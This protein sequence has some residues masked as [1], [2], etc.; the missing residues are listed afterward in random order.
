ML[1]S[2]SFSATTATAGYR[3]WCCPWPWLSLRIEMQPLLLALEFVL[4]H[5][6]GLE[7]WVLGHVIVGDTGFFVSCTQTACTAVQWE[8]TTH[9]LNCSQTTRCQ[10][11]AA[12][13][14]R[15]KPLLSLVFWSP[16]TSAPVERVFSQSTDVE[17]FAWNT[18]PFEVQQ[19]S[20]CVTLLLCDRQVLL[21]VLSADCWVL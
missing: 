9:L 10:H 6:L 5:C 3:Q 8:S 17:H 20:F 11:S 14:A 18:G 16:A 15:M 13:F 12:L 2:I 4:R 19:P 1:S 21:T 7:G